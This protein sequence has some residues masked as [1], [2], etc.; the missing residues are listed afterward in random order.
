MFETWAKLHAALNDLPAALLAAAVLFEL[1]GWLLK[2]ETVRAA[3]VWMLWAGV[4]GGWAAFIAGNQAE[5]S[6]DHDDLIHEVMERHESLALYTMIA[7]TLILALHLWRRGALRPVELLATRALGVVGLVLLML[8][9]IAGGRAVFDHGAGV[10]NT[11]LIKA[12]RDRGLD[13]A[14]V[15]PSPTDSAPKK[16][17]HSHAPGT[18][19]HDH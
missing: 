13:T 11:D 2:R 19:A 6:I 7:F 15:K 4:V 10:S 3:G 14:F 17:S 12:V 1:A 5:G 18:P 16:P 8:T 9:G